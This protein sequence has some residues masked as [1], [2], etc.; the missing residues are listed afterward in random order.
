M[1]KYKWSKPN[2]PLSI[3][4]LKLAEEAAEVGTELTDEFIGLRPF[5]RK[6]ILTELDH[7]EF[8]VGIMRSRLTHVVK[9]DT[10]PPDN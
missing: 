9:G 7:V 5:S 4:A 10:V 8:L 2:I 1:N 3:L 6:R